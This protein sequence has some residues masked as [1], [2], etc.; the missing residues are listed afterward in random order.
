MSNR[1]DFQINMYGD[2][3]AKIE[4]LQANFVNVVNVVEKVDK[5]VNKTV[6]N[7]GKQL[8]ALN[9]N[10]IVDTIRN[11]TDAVSNISAPGISFEKASADFSALTGVAG[12]ELEELEQR[13][14]EV[15]I[16]SG[17]GANGAIEAYKLLASQIQV[18]KIGIEGLNNLHKET[19]TLAQASGMSMGDAANSMAGTINQ[20]GL[21]ASEANRVINVLA[22]G[23]KY[24]AAE[25]PDLAQSFKVVG[26]AA[27]AA[28]LTIEQTAGAVEVLSKNNLKGA[29]AGTALRNIVLKMQT[30]LG[31]DFSKTSLTQ[32]LDAL[33]PKLKDATYLSKLFG[34]ENVS[35]AQF[36]IA[37]SSA[38]REMTN[39]VTGTNVA[40]EQAAITTQTT[41]FKMQQ[42][43]AAID[44]AKISMFEFLGPSAGVLTVASEQLVMFAQMIPLIKGVGSVIGWL[45]KMENLKKAATKSL[46]VVEGIWAGIQWALNAA[47]WACPLTWI[48]GAILALIGIIVYL[49]TCVEG[50]GAQWDSVVSFC[51][52]CFDLFVE[53]IKF[54]WNTMIDGLMIGLDYIKIGWYKFKEACGLGDSSENQAAIASINADIEARKQAITDGAKKIAELKAKTSDS[55]AWEL[56]IK[57]DKAPAT[58]LPATMPPEIATINAAPTPAVKEPDI[59]LNLG[60]TKGKGGSSGSEKIDLDKI[61]PQDMKGST[62]YGAIVSKI[63][64]IRMPSIATAAA[65]LALP[66]AI[67]T[68]TPAIPDL[69]Q[70]PNIEQSIAQAT[71]DSKDYS[72]QKAGKNITVKACDKI[73]IHIASADA[74]G[75]AEIERR[76]NQIATKAAIQATT[77]ILT[78]EA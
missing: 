49:C 21:Q 15:G 2:V 27:N 61:G 64:Q 30:V 14:R 68:T 32:A 60:D 29:E 78:N 56:K 77:Q 37:N 47:L 3:F 54:G 76:V 34:M 22:A 13:S 10:A 12:K 72:R 75:Y 74:K 31:V 45:T 59:N 38:V 69:P 63:S 41:A 7:I 71:A 4:K 16:S 43:R 39:Q 8:S 51:K 65:S 42:W 50:W 19:I 67:A 23:S 1:A 53:T 40:Q 52:N 55:L 24:G 28:G 35:A 5:S 9:L 57:D 6:N 33:Q 20:F 17:L 73:E 26:A 36:L 46:N 18:D 66:L 48:I 44:D 58:N 25:I 11:V 62:A 70:V